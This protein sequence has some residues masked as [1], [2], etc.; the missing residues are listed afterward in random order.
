M[1]SRGDLVSPDS[2]PKPIPIDQEVYPEIPPAVLQDLRDRAAA[3]HGQIVD[4][5]QNIIALQESLDRIKAR[6]G[7]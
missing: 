4:H 5:E 2:P 6:L 1:F 7:L 3:L